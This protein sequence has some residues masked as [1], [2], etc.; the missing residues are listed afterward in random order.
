VI[1]SPPLNASALRDTFVKYGRSA[2]HVYNL[3][4]KPREMTDWELRIV[5][6][7]RQIPDLSAF[8]EKLKGN[9]DYSNEAVLKAPSQII[10]VV[11]NQDRL[12][13]V[14]LASQHIGKRLY[15]AI[16]CEDAV[17][18]WAAFNL[19]WIVPETHGSA[20]HLWEPHA[21]KQITGGMKGEHQL[22]R[23]PGKLPVQKKRRH[24]EILTLP[25]PEPTVYGDVASLANH[26][27]IVFLSWINGGTDRAFFAP[28]ARNQATFDWFAISH[29]GM[30]QPFQGTVENGHHS[31][32]ATGLDFI[33]DA[34]L[35]A[36]K[37]L[38]KN[39]KDFVTKFFASASKNWHVTFVIPKRVGP[40][41]KTAQ[42]IDFGPKKARRQWERYVVEYVLELDDPTIKIEPS[43]L[44]HGHG[45][46]PSVGQL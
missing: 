46:G 5:P 30:V 18:F 6:L 4:K 40:H 26:L 35:A 23:L 22:R 21:R 25:F 45:K 34:L 3:I 44:G 2:R 1:E 12:I 17:K 7:L 16:L 10:T 24:P 37:L 36:R 14:A 27:K 41:W 13:A 15:E 31:T 33:T 32:K 43:S 39:H 28:G 20:G 38:P 29:E 9:L 42:P 19:F 8:T 11:P